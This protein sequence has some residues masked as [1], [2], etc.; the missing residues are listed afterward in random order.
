MGSVS[1]EETYALR[2]TVH[3]MADILLVYRAFLFEVNI[4]A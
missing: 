2:L 3:W 4:M 1:V